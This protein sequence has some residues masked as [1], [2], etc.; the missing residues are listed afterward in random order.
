MHENRNPT[1]TPASSKRTFLQELLALATG[2]GLVH[3]RR[4][5]VPSESRDVHAQL[6]GDHCAADFV[7][8][9]HLLAYMGCSVPTLYKQYTEIAESDGVR[10]LDFGID[11]DFASCIDGLVLVD[12][13]RLKPHKKA[14][15]MGDPLSQNSCRLDR[16]RMIRGETNRGTSGSIRTSLQR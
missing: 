9:K 14:R 15:Y 10:F 11:P 5:Y 8:L 3:A 7:R 13:Q 4:P 16:N 12:V 2:F 6:T 1:Q